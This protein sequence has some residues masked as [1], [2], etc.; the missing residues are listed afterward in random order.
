M[1]SFFKHISFRILF[2]TFRRSINSITTAE[3]RK[4]MK[5]EAATAAEKK[6]MNKNYKT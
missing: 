2:F 6:L 3:K 5:N 1:A 4:R